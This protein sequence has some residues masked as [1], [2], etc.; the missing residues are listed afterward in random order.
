MFGPAFLVA[1][2]TEFRRFDGQ[3]MLA[4]HQPNRPPEER[5][6]FLEIDEVDDDLML[7]GGARRR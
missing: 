5:E 1:P 6:Q 7:R 4:L 2:V 3:L